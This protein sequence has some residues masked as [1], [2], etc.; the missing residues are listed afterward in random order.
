MWTTLVIYDHNIN[1]AAINDLGIIIIPSIHSITPVH[2][3]ILGY[4]A[5]NIGHKKYEK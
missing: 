1:V 5:R 4:N 3:L 2:F